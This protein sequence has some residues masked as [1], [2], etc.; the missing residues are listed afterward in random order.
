MPEHFDRRGIHLERL[1]DIQVILLQE[2]Q[3][4]LASLRSSSRACDYVLSIG[5]KHRIC[6]GIQCGD[7]GSCG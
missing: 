7:V 4:A 3:L 6:I 1:D 2:Q 5:A